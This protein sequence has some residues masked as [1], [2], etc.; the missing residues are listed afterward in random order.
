MI[1]NGWRKYLLILVAVSLSMTACSGFNTSATSTAT[2]PLLTSTPTP[3]ISWFPA[4]NTPTFLPTQLSTP[5]AVLLPGLGARILENA[6]SNMDQWD[7]SAYIAGQGTVTSDQLTLSIPEG[8]EG[9]S[10]TALLRSFQSSDYFTR[11]KV[12]LSL[13]KGRDQIGFLF[14]TTSPQDFYRFSITCSGETRLERVVAGQPFVIRDWA[15]SPDA[16]LGAPAEVTL[17]VSADG[18]EMEF[19]LDERF[20]FSIQ[21]GIFS[22]G[23]VGIY[24]RASSDSP[25]TINL[26]ELEAYLVIPGQDPSPQSPTSVQPTP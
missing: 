24:L 12:R 8:S 23:G 21:D 7:I 13:C 16:P 14:R 22:Q 17:A 6:F 9:A 11:V 4:T 25:V 10:I 19:F 5:T 1:L 20:Q 3:T 15:P 26:K 2:V 18:Q